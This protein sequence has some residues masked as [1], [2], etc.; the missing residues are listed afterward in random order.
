MFA[1]QLSSTASPVIVDSLETLLEFI[2]TPFISNCSLYDNDELED[3]IINKI[4]TDLV[5]VNNFTSDQCVSFVHL[6]SDESIGSEKQVPQNIS[7]SNSFDDSQSSPMSINSQSSDDNDD[8]EPFDSNEWTVEDK[9][10]GKIRPPRLYEF[11]R[12]LLDNSRYT[13]YA[14][15]LNKDEGLFKI[16]K[17][18]QVASLWKSVKVRKTNGS[19]NYDTLAR[20]IRYYYQS[21]AMIKT[22]TKHTY[23]FGQI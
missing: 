21:G 14:S 2:S 12:L 22:H 4:Y 17:P 8:E 6:N 3:I 23:C 20:G 10:G 15:W 13:S 16:H 1:N 18:S 11:L 5:T 7:K 9:S 19:M